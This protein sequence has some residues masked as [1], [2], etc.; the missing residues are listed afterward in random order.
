MTLRW[1]IAAPFLVCFGT[2]MIVKFFY[3]LH[4]EGISRDVL[5]FLHRVAGASPSSPRWHS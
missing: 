1:A 2:G 4:P 5:T 3:G